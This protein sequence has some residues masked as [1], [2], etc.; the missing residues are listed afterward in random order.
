MALL[1]QLLLI[2]SDLIRTDGW[3]ELSVNWDDDENSKN[4]LLD[5]KKE[6]GEIQFKAGY[7]II[8]RS[9]LDHLISQPTVNGLLSYER[10]PLENNSYHGNVL[11]KGNL[12][13]PT[14]KKIQAGLAL[15]V[16]KVVKRD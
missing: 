7:A 10:S 3:K 5:Q 15:F 14:I 16:S 12:P 9:E 4:V 8:P 1:H 13:K 6:N 11:L 2:F